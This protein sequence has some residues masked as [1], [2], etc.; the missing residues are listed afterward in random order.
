MVEKWGRD[1]QTEHWGTLRKRVGKEYQSEKIRGCS[2][3]EEKIQL[4]NH[5]LDGLK[6]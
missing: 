4:H 5:S 2:L 3:K 1:K 6:I